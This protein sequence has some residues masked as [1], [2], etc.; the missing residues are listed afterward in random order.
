M[1]SPVEVKSAKVLFA[2]SMLVLA[3]IWLVNDGL[4][5]EKATSDSYRKRIAILDTRLGR[6]KAYNEKSLDFFMALVYSSLNREIYGD[7]VSFDEASGKIR[8]YWGDFPRDLRPLFEDKKSPVRLLA[9]MCRDIIQATDDIDKRVAFL[10]KAFGLC[11]NQ[12]SLAA[13][14]VGFPETPELFTG[15]VGELIPKIARIDSRQGWISVR[16]WVWDGGPIDGGWGY[17]YADYM[18]EGTVSFDGG[19]NYEMWE[20]DEQ[21]R[22]KCLRSDSSMEFEALLDLWWVE[23]LEDSALLGGF[24]GSRGCQSKHFSSRRWG[25]PSPGW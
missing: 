23:R 3:V 19:V 17:G 15:F 13:F 9:E 12:D 1:K 5:T 25:S 21:L 11:L 7:S 10:E 6:A 14:R 18:I 8:F 22:K 4:I 2:F 20:R 24:V 16:K